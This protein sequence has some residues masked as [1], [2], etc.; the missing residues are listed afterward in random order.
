KKP[1]LDVR[2]RIEQLIE[3]AGPVTVPTLWLRAVRGVETLERIGSDEARRG[4]EKLAQG[5]EG[6]RQT[7]E[8]KTALARRKKPSE[9]RSAGTPPAT[10]RSSCSGPR[11]RRLAP[12][13]PWGF[14]P[15]STGCRRRW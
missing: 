15:G 7:V 3:R 9:W 2:R 8:A 10:S 13:A 14:A 6:S 1:S 12:L 4:L 11:R 5:P